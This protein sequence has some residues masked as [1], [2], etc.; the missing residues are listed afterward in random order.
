MYTEQGAAEWYF[1]LAN[2]I[3]EIVE[4]SLP[5]LIEVATNEIPTNT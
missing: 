4:V 3:R 1:V 2:K 5:R